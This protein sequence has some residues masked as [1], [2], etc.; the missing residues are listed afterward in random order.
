MNTP[1]F[2]ST[3]RRNL[4]DRYLKLDHDLSGPHKKGFSMPE[5]RAMSK[6]RDAVLDAYA[7]GLPLTPLSTCPFCVAIL[8]YPVDV[9]G[10]DGPWWE[11]GPLA[12]YSLPNG[13]EHFRVLLGAIDFKSLQPSEAATNDDVYAGPGVPYVVPRMLNDIPSM[14]VVAS[15]IL[16]A[17][18]YTGYAM[19]YFSENPVHGSLLHQP[20]GREA[21]QVLNEKGEYEGWFAA[22]DII[23]FDLQSWVDKGALLWINPG[24]AALTLQSR[25]PCPYVNLPG[26][27]APQ[28]IIKGKLET[29]PLPTG[30]KFQPFE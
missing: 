16:I 18:G 19:A 11:K 28:R 8:E 20:W 26:V 17:P 27:R 2:S 21:Y 9:E 3:E 10:L 25:P 22:N 12:N 4:I 14:K 6:E 24:D 13:C 30:E 7:K 29:R 1:G 15:M 23:D 5:L